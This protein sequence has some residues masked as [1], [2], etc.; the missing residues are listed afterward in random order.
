MYPFIET[1]MNAIALGPVL[2]SLPRLYALLCALA[3][4]LALRF[5]LGLPKAVLAR[6]TTGLI[7]AWLVGARLA[8]IVLHHESYVLAPLDAIKLWQP[9]YHP[10][11]G[12]LGALVWSLWALRGRWL[13]LGGAAV[14]LTGTSLVW[15]ALVSVMPGGSAFPV[16]RIPA[17]SLED[18][19]GHSVD[20]SDLA[21]GGM[22]V[23]VNLWA[24]W[25]PP[26]R[27]EMPLLQE[28]E[29]QGEVRVV[30]VNQ[31]EELLPVVRYLDE[32]SLHFTHALRDPSQT[33]M[34]TVEAPGL[35]TTILFDADG[36]T[37]DIHVGELTRAH[38]ASWLDD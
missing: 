35:P 29:A 6:Y 4:L 21:D 11:G 9:G 5:L 17:L 26:C 13:A 33:L 7:L 2:L 19:D 3:L 24:T 27:R 38:L 8:H 34:T 10:V 1:T 23:V 16:A 30:V 28:L 18:L 37:R 20:L 12:W 22:P 25:C 31:G 14:L 15:L 36:T 32:Q